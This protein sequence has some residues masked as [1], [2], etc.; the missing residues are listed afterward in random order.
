VGERFSTQCG[1][2]ASKKPPHGREVWK[3]VGDLPC[4]PQPFRENP[5]FLHAVFQ[6]FKDIKKMTVCNLQNKVF[7]KQTHTK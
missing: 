2:H 4:F 3:T 7:L 1:C 5:H 6:K